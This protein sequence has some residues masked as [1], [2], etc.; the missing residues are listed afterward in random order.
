MRTMKNIYLIYTFLSMAKIYLRLVLNCFSKVYPVL[1][2]F[3]L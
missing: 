1:V 3:L 2:N